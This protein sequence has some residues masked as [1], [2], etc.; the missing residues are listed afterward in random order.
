MLGWRKVKKRQIEIDKA[1]RYLIS[2]QNLM[3]STSFTV[4]GLCYDAD[5]ID[6]RITAFAN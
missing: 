2:K 1:E 3:I 4:I 5:I 6:S